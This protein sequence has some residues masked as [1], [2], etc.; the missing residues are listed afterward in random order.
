MAG[1]LSYLSYLPMLEHADVQ[2]MVGGILLGG[3]LIAA[4][5]VVHSRLRTRESVEAAIVPSRNFSLAGVSDVFVEG[6]IKFYDSILAGDGRRHLSFVGTIFLFLLLS[7]LIGLIPGMPAI[8]NTVWINVGLA[9]TVFIYFNYQGIREHG[10]G[11][12]LKHFCGPIALLAPFMFVLEMFSLHLRIVTLNLRLY[13]NIK[14]DHI[15]VGIFTDLLGAGI[16]A[17]FYV[18]GTFVCFMQ[19][20]IFTTLTMVY[21]LLATQHE[22][23]GHH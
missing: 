1:D 4:G 12:Y 20:F 11:S 3:G 6:F 21:I 22:E 19:A 16:P 2:R 13:W 23:E 10:L 7:N 17:L 8:T 5:A 15:V 18:L 14:A 9:A